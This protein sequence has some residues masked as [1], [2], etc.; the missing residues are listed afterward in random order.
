MDG[1]T[2]AWRS[3][4][5]ARVTAVHALLTAAVADLTVDQV[6]HVERPGV[7]PIAFSLMHVVGSE[8]R[9]VTRHLHG[10]KNVWDSA[11]WAERV[12][13]DGPIPYRGT[14]VDEAMRVRFR[15]IE[16]WR[17]YQRDVFVRT[18]HVLANAP[19]AVFDEDAF[20]EGRPRE[21][22][23]GFL[24]LLVPEGRVVRVRDI[25][26]AYFFQHGARHLGEIEHARALVGLVG[27]S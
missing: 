1:T 18:E 23:P 9:V 22:R 13:L 21:T 10:G 11:G 19:L 14:P 5:G 15:H 7:L 20:P 24:S 6:N 3:S 26:E 4:I 27:L 17:E 25:C 2:E 12:G 8:D 16:Q